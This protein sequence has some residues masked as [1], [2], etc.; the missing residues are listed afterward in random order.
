VRFRAPLQPITISICVLRI[1]ALPLQK[2]IQHEI[3]FAYY[4]VGLVIGLFFFVALV[5]SG[6]DTR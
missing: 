2:I 5:F 4:L 6:K 3:L 1:F